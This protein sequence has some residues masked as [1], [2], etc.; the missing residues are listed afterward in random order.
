MITSVHRCWEVKSNNDS[1]VGN[2]LVTKTRVVSGSNKPQ[3]GQVVKG[4]A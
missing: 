4:G 3:K 2:I 1:N